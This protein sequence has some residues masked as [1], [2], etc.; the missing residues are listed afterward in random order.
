M[1]TFF[2]HGGFLDVVPSDVIAGLVLVRMQQK[3]K[4]YLSKHVSQI[5][6]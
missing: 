3:Q 1:A 4:A 6:F 2:H 5:I